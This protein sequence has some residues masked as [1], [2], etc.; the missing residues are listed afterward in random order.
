MEATVGPDATDDWMIETDRLGA[1][2]SAT[3][4]GCCVLS[5]DFGTPSG[6]DGFNLG[7]LYN[8][9]LAR[10]CLLLGFR[11]AD[12]YHEYFLNVWRFVRDLHLSVYLCCLLSQRAF[13]CSIW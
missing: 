11:E 4:R 12:E 13:I 2:I 1:G 8:W 10:I 6:W 9:N 5:P 3:L 7:C